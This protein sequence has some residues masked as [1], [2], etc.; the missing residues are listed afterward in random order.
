MSK[1]KTS[2]AQGRG[3]LKLKPA[4]YYLSLSK[5]SVYRVVARGLLKPNRATRHLLFSVAELDRFLREG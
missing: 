3:A 4:A 2:P 1:S 5:P